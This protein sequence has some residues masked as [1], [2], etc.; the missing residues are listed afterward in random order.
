MLYLQNLEYLF[1]DGLRFKKHPTHF[2]LAEAVEA[3]QKIGAKQTYLIH[4]AHDYDHDVVNA[5]LPP[6]IA[7]AY[8][9]LQIES[10]LA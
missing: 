10:E 4:L 7:L 9:G 6:G 3:A 5:T 2:S 8:D 1:I